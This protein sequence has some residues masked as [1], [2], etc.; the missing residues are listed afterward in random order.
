PFLLMHF[1]SPIPWW[2]VVAAAAAIAATAFLSYRRPLAP[3]TAVQRGALTALRG[4]SLAAVL[5][6]LCR[7]ILLRPPAAARD[8]VVPILVDVSRSMRIA[9]VKG[10]TRIARAAEIVSRTLLPALSGRYKPEV[11]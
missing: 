8:I 9:D 5:F 7:P 11:Y 4:L 6:F 10:Q 1:A 2:L 3:L